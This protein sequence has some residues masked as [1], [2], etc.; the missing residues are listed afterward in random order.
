MNTLE[1]LKVKP[2]RDELTFKPIEVKQIEI[3][4]PQQNDP[5]RLISQKIEIIDKRKDAKM[6]INIDKFFEK[7]KNSKFNKVV[8]KKPKKTQV[9]KIR[10]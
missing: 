3:I 10:Q 7:L 9:V 6:N 5:E 8:D 1:K 2:T 4:F